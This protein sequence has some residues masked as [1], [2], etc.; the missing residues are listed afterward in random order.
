MPSYGYFGFWVEPST[1]RS[2]Y[3]YI[4]LTIWLYIC[5]HIH[6]RTYIHECIH[7]RIRLLCPSPVIVLASL[8]LQHLELLPTL[9]CD[10]RDVLRLLLPAGSL[11]IACCAIPA[12]KLPIL[13]KMCCVV[14]VLCWS[15][16]FRSRPRS[17]PFHTR[18]RPGPPMYHPRPTPGWTNGRFSHRLLLSHPL[19]VGYGS[20]ESCDAW[21]QSTP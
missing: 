10:G 8:C 21:T 17:I 2:I 18:S 13:I 16:P 7:V 11:R 1:L 3:I 14:A 5:T 15:G 19:R 12:P 4:Y 20:L 6:E 9:L